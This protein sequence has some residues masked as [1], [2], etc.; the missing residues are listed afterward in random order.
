MMIMFCVRCGIE[1]GK[2]IENLCE[3]CF[4]ESREIKIPNEVR[5]IICP[6]C[7]SYLKGK[8]WIKRRNLESAVIE[9]CINEVV[10]LSEIKG[11]LKIV[12]IKGEIE[13]YSNELPTKV[14]LKIKLSFKELSKT[15]ESRG[16]VFYQKCNR[17]IE[18]SH[19]KYNAIVQI[20][21][22]DEKELSIVETIIEDFK[23][24]NGKPEISEI[25]KIANGIDVKFM[26]VNKARLFAKRV[27]ERVRAKIKESAKI[28]GI[29]E[30]NVHYITT[31]S[32]RG[33][34]IEIGKLICIGDGIFK[35]L[36]FRGGKIIVK[37]LENEETKELNYKDIKKS[38]IVEES[39]MREVRL[40]SF[41][42][43]KVELLDIKKGYRFQL[44]VSSVQKGLKVGD[45]G[46]LI[47]FKDREYVIG[48]ML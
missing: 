27:S 15:L 34:P 40:E 5:I 23:I 17:C 25:K 18:V 6:S 1:E 28:S 36:E 33:F 14:E 21:G 20:R 37:N 7:F 19:G 22:F 29:K 12:D 41:E 13:G 30:G 9:S 46:V 26:S 38:L 16:V 3:K 8:K 42:G 35:V 10:K 11:G 47:T 31:I 48:K 45:L 32:I 44:P 39:C 24:I 2:L 43:G 4:W